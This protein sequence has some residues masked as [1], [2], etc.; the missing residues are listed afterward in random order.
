MVKLWCF[1]E[2]SL[3]GCFIIFIC[4]LSIFIVRSVSFWRFGS[5]LSLLLVGCWCLCFKLFMLLVMFIFFV[6]MKRISLIR[7]GVRCNL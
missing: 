1:G 7:V 6:L 4:S 3:C 2:V 5:L